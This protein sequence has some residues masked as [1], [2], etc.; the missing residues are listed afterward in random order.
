MTVEEKKIVIEAVA[1]VAWAD[2]KLAMG[3]IDELTKT[4]LSIGDIS[5]VDMEIIFNQKIG[6]ELV[7]D[8]LKAF[9]PSIIVRILQ[10]CFR[11]ALSDNELHKDELSIIHKIAGLIWHAD[12]LDQVINWLRKSYFAEKMYLELMPKIKS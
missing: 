1:A 3:E 12:D 7:L 11:M 9:S 5:I 6:I 10:F 4:C 2:G 8:K